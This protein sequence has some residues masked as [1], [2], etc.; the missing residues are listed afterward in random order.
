VVVIYNDTTNNSMSLSLNQYKTYIVNGM[1]NAPTFTSNNE[2]LIN[3]L[4]SN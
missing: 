3:I 2:Y 4:H 1:I